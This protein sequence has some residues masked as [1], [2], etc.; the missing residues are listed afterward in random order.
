MLA[1]AGGKGGVGTTTV[2]LALAGVLARSG[3]DPVAVDADVDMPDLHVL[4]GVDR[5][6]TGNALAAGR[7]VGAVVQRAPALPGVGVV[8][9]G[10]PGAI[11][12][13]LRRLEGWH[14]PVLGDGP[15]GAG[16]D[17]ARPLRVCDRTVLV[18]TVTPAAVEDTR[19]TAA[20]ARRLGASPLVALVREPAGAGAGEAEAE[21]GFDCPVERLPPVAADRV[22]AHPRVRAVCDT[23]RQMLAC[24]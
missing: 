20:M 18:T 5:G 17:A 3:R 2:V 6:P 14:G 13:A 1:V 19:K 24:R 9:S 21:A 15:A 16:G 11:P 7:P 4:A 23:V 10:T 8:A 22:H 12:A